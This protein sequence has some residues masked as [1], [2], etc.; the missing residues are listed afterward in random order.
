MNTSI[1]KPTN[2]HIPIYI[3]I[4]TTHT[5]IYTWL[6]ICI[7]IYIYICM[8]VGWNAH[9]WKN[10]IMPYLLLMMFLINEIQVLQHQWKKWVDSKRNYVVKRPYLVTFYENIM[11]SLW[12]FQQT[13][14]YTIT[15]NFIL[16]LRTKWFQIT[17]T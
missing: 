5:H 1:Y 14:I 11:V 16:Q 9:G 17:H 12:T 10:C 2:I 8:R 3:Y 6:Y 13:F 15:P 7:Y 4:Y